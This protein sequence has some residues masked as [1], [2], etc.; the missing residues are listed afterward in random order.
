MDYSTPGFS[1][2]HQLL[3]LVQT[4]VHQVSDAIQQPYPLSSPSPPAFSLSQHQ[5]LFQWVSS[6]HQVA[7]VLAF[8]LHHYSFQWI[9]RTDFVWDGLVGSPCSP[10]DSQESSSTRQFKASILWCS[11][12]FI[13]QISHPYKTTGENI[14]LTRWTFVGK[15]M[16]LLFNMLPRL[17]IAFFPRS[18]RLLISWLQ[19]PS[20]VIFGAPQNKVS[21]CFHCF[22]V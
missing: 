9:F 3:A 12:F 10:S 7:K 4:H 18:K 1:V 17:V 2:H 5:G 11:S 13:V 15:L 22:P 19:S 14:A 8:Q 21:H 20:V 6:W 16:S